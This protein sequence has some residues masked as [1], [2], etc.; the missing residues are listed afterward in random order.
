MFH[1]GTEPCSTP[2]CLSFDTSCSIAISRQSES[3]VCMANVAV[4]VLMKIMDLLRKANKNW[5]QESTVAQEHF[6]LPSPSGL[7]SADVA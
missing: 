1:V 5:E 2:V 7:F 3:G 6:E 4:I